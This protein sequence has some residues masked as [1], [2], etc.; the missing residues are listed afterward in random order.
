MK[1]KQIIKNCMPTGI[2]K[3]FHDARAYVELLW[4]H[5]NYRRIIKR[6]KHKKE[7]LNVLFMAIYD[8][9]WKY[10][11]V[12]KLMLSDPRFNPIILVCPAV[13][14][15]REH[16]L[17]TMNK[18]C[19]SF[20]K[21][22]YAF[23]RTYDETTDSYIDAHAY[24]PDIIFYTNPYEIVIDERYYLYNFKDS[25]T[26]YVNY[27]YINVHHEWAVNLPF[28]QKVWRYYV[29]CADN[30]NL[31]KSYSP[32]DARNVKVVG[33]PMYDAFITGSANGIDW[34]IKDKKLK[35][36]IWSP[37]HTISNRAEEMRFSTFELYYELMLQMAKKYKDYIQ[38]VFKPHPLLKNALYNLSGWG[39]ERTDSYYKQW[40]NGENIAIA[41]GE[42]VDLFNSSDAM[43]NDSA[44]FTIEYLYENKPCLFLSNYDRQKDSNVV[45]LKAFNCWYHAETPEEIE[46]F[47]RDVVIEG[48][49]TM[50]E[51]RGMFYDEVLLPPNGCYVADNIIQDIKS[52]QI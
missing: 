32:I 15:G 4:Y 11:S 1:I 19:S 24:N 38:I 35:R 49:D 26:C 41:E 48:N 44:S 10:D 21:K 14:R 12:Y 16:M 2:W 40:E 36:I 52:C 29:E 33:Y 20:Q 3:K 7:P 18:C 8:S 13:N 31:I 46:R 30:F 42:Y 5:R 37:H 27:G 6:L 9:N 34:K 50:K 39:K 22:G 23:V 47:I 43:I 28:H 51:R 45:S 17:E 25:L